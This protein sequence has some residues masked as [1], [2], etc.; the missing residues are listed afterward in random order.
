MLEGGEQHLIL[1]TF[2]SWQRAYEFSASLNKRLERRFGLGPYVQVFAITRPTLRDAIAHI[3][4]IPQN[5][6]PDYEE[7]D[8]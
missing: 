6:Y 2:T 7:D 3:E 5:Y 1:G 4:E 8:E